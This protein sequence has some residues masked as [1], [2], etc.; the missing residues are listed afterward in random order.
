[1]IDLLIINMEISSVPEWVSQAIDEVAAH[2]AK[3]IEKPFIS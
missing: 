2:V 1:L 3:A